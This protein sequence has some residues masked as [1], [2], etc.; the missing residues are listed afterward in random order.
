MMY[1]HVKLEILDK[2]KQS[3]IK[4]IFELDKS[5]LSE[6]RNDIIEPFLKKNEFQ[7]NGY[8]IKPNTVK[9]LLIK[10][11][12]KSVKVYAQY[13]NDNLP[14]NVIMYISPS[15]IL[16][17]DK[18]TKDITKDVINSTKEILDSHK[19][20]EIMKDNKKDIDKTKV[21]LVHGHDDLAK[22]KVARFI[23]Q[24][25]LKA[26]I[27]HERANAGKTIIEKIEEH[28]NVGFAIV[29]YTPDD[30]GSKMDT[31]LTLKPRAR[32][33]VIFEHGYLIGK[34]GRNNVCALLKDDIEKPSDI[35]GILYIAFDESGAWKTEVAREMKNSGYKIDL[36]RLLS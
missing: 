23:E 34:V 7:F 13:E 4:E 26:I 20:Q 8:F 9:R 22:V 15:S 19:E 24:M 17:Y 31:E 5:D 11:T 2:S 28:T 21:F 1:Y 33:N 18:Y 25:G 29:L 3:G 30:V 6:I 32:Q 36:N 12:K 35:S 10:E 14:S 16:S 27:L